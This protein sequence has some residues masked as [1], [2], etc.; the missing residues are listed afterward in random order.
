MILV[1]AGT[2]YTKILD[3]GKLEILRTDHVPAGLR[4]DR[5]T[6]HNAWKFASRTVNELVAL[7][8]GGLA[9]IEDPSFLLLDVGARDTKLVRIKDRRYAGCGWN[10]SCGSLTGFTLELIGRYFDVD[11]HGLEK[12][13]VGLDF[14]CGIFGISEMFDK[15]SGGM[16]H[17][18]AVAALTRGLAERIYDFA[19]RPDRLCLSGGLC[20]NPLFLASLPCDVQPLGRAVLL[21][22]LGAGDHG[23][24]DGGEKTHCNHFS[25]S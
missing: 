3:N 7:A 2:A 16:K 25:S 1:D 11:F 18:K 9:L 10:E 14:T 6:G 24:G 17:E 15:I 21:K 8:R 4:A 19:G 22:G 13:T 5:A 20:E 12:E 23:Q